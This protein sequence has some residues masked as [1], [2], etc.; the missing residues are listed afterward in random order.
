M[1]S[2]DE[3]IADLLNN[4]S[5]FISFITELELLGYKDINPEDIGR[6]ES[7]LTEVTIIDINSGIKKIV[8]SLRKSFK[9]KLPDAIIAASSYYLN[10]PLFTA[11]KALSKLSELNVLLYKK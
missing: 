4:R 6:I 2:G 3:T 5:V 7:F 9:I 1:L 8:V 11:D 10:L